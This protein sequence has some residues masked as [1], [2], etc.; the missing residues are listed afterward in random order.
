MASEIILSGELE[1]T[2]SVLKQILESEGE[3]IPCNSTVKAVIL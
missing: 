1:K 3:E 2:C